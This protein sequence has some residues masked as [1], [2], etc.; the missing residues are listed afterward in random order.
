VRVYSWI[1]GDAP[2]Q[3]A[4][5]AAQRREQGFTAVKMN[6]SAQLAPIATPAATAEIV[7]RVASVRDVLG[8]DGD[9]AIDFHGRVTTPMARR[10]LAM[11]ED[12]QPMFVEEPVL[13]EH[14]ENLAALA[15]GTSIPLATGERLY[16]R[17][18]FR[19][20]FEAGVAVVQPDVAHAGGISEV[21]RIAAVAE[22]YDVLVAPH[23]PLGPIALAACLQVDFGIPNVLIQEQSLG[24]HYNMGSD[25]FD[26]LLNPDVF[27]FTDGW[28][29]RPTGPGLGV[30]I[31]ADAVAKA[32]ARLLE[33]GQH[34]R[35]PTW[36]HADGSLAEW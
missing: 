4:Q 7:D 27:T 28:V 31:D 26:Y 24:I 6:A 15:A 19:H 8:P 18:D 21:R 36:R 13:P 30:E 17:H 10:L 16:S 33:S 3:V 23:C 2:G 11:L 34:W 1:G 14:G 20:A 25:L 35:T 32:S 12:L 22:M 5:E 9:I 29:S